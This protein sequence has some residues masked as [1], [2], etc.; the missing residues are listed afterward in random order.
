MVENIT[1]IKCGTMIIVNVVQ[2]SK[3]RCLQKRLFLQSCE[4]FRC[5]ESI[6]DYDDDDDDDDDVDDDP[7]IT[8]DEI[9]ETTKRI[10]KKVALHMFLLILC[11]LCKLTPNI[12][13]LQKKRLICVML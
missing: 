4:T 6:D 7:V 9:L 10:A 11:K 3:K 2:K 8:F 1:Q 13:Y 12:H 5:V